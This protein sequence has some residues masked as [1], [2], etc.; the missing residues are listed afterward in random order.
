MSRFPFFVDAPFD[1]NFRNRELVPIRFYD[2]CS[3]SVM[4]A[5]LRIVGFRAALHG[6]RA[7]P[8]TSTLL[9]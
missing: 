5:T 3:Q 4:V 7:G 8:V 6:R 9:F 2:Y 1:I